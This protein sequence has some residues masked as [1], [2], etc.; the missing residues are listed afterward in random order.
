MKVNKR[1]LAA[2]LC[3]L[4]SSLVFVFMANVGPARASDTQPAQM[5]EEDAAGSLFETADAW[6]AES[7]EEYKEDEDQEPFREE[8][9]EEGEEGSEYEN[10]PSGEEYESYTQEPSD[11]ESSHMP[12]QGDDDLAQAQAE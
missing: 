10:A 12:P 1:L 4:L 3:I 7:E 8:M 9:S 5:D 11:E 6:A 2:S